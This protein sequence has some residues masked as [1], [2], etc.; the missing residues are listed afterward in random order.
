MREL[1]NYR[2]LQRPVVSEVKKTD[3][4]KL[5][6]KRLL[7][8]RDW[9]FYAVWTTRIKQAIDSLYNNETKS[10]AAQNE[11]KRLYERLLERRRYLK[12]W[13]KAD[14]SVI[15]NALRLL[16]SKMSKD[17][18]EEK[19]IDVQVTTRCQS[20][21]IGMFSDESMARSTPLIEFKLSVHSS[22]TT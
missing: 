17:K 19:F 6:R 5:K 1:K 12:K 11:I 8:V 14:S 3:S 16:K 13:D 18:D 22:L 4:S 20:L 9:F 10:K 21:F 2:P 7:I 15:D